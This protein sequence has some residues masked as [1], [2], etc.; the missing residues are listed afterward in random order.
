MNQASLLHK[1]ALSFGE[2]P[3]VTA[4]LNSLYNYHQLSN[5][6][7]R[8][9]GT[10][11]NELGLNKGDRVAIMMRNAP[12]FFEVLYDAWHAGLNAVPINA[13]LHQKE[14][15]YILEN[16]GARV[17][18]ITEDLKAVIT[19]LADEISGLEAVLPTSDTNHDALLAGPAVPMADCAPEDIAW[20]FY[21][22]GTTGRP[23]GA[24]LSQRNLMAMVM[25]YFSDMDT[26][27]EQENG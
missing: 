7:A 15:A 2:R 10:M 14:A 3:A 26:I 21:T 13:K 20:L 11:A 24:M 1:A 9:D 8:L 12:A 23:K 27:T 6:A 18:F 16:S 22:S 17:C 4:S 25:N 19:P 5:R